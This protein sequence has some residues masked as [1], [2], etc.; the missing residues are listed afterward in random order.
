MTMPLPPRER[1]LKTPL[2]SSEGLPEDEQFQ[3]ALPPRPLRRDDPA[4]VPNRQGPRGRLTFLL[5]SLAGTTLV[6]FLL[7][8]VALTALNAAPPRETRAHSSS[9]APTVESGARPVPS[10]QEDPG[11]L[12]EER[13]AGSLAEQVQEDREEM[14]DTFNNLQD[15]FRNFKPSLP[16]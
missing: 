2:E 1:A 9:S 10:P 5:L 3:E 6:I 12:L 11:S 15:R 7:V 13:N 4:L 14:R 8:L 16:W